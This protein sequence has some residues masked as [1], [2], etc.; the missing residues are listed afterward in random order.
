MKKMSDL[1]IEKMSDLIIGMKESDLIIEMKESDLVFR[2]LV[3]VTVAGLRLLLRIFLIVLISIAALL[4][5]C[6]F[7]VADW[8]RGGTRR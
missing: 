8:L 5:C 2:D 3:M 7:R 6:S 1:I 4:Y